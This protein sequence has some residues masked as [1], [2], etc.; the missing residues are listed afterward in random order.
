MRTWENGF[1]CGIQNQE[2]LSGGGLFSPYW[3]DKLEIHK[4]PIPHYLLLGA[5]SWGNMEYKK[6]KEY[7]VL[8]S[9]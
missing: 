8:V 2:N 3:Y 5:K 1:G 6:Q 4:K 7:V 9:N